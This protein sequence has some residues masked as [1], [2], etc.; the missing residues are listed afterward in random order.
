MKFQLAPCHRPVTN[1]RI[2]VHRYTDT[3]LP[4]PPSLARAFW[5]SFRTVLLTDRG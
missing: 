3:R 2:M 5:W 1:Q 4:A